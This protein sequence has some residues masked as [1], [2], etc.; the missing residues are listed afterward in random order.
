[1]ILISIFSLQEL[2]LREN[3]VISL[4]RDYSSDKIYLNS[5][6]YVI[7]LLDKDLYP[8]NT[9]ISGSFVLLTA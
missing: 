2:W 1:M 9:S 8:F 5:L 3:P 6:P 7:T 4:T